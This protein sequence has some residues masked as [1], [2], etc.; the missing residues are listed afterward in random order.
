[1]LPCIETLVEGRLAS[2]MFTV[3]VGANIENVLSCFSPT[4]SSRAFGG[5]LGFSI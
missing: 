3:Q 4:L 2:Q 1:M 5:Q